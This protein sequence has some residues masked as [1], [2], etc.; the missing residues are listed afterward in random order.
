MNEDPNDSLLAG[1][2]NIFARTSEFLLEFQK[3]YWH[4]E[5]QWIISGSFRKNLWI[6][7]S[8]FQR[9][10][11]RKALLFTSRMSLGKAACLSI[12]TLRTLYS[13]LSL[14]ATATEAR[15]VAWFIIWISYAEKMI[16][17][18]FLIHRLCNCVHGCGAFLW[19]QVSLRYDQIMNHLEVRAYQAAIDLSANCLWLH[20]KRNI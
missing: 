6:S 8:K 12:R 18:H 19:I 14:Q 4:P 7:K 5:L 17:H 16:T 3:F 9:S 1:E 10:F 2:L 11:S 13:A 15:N 20:M